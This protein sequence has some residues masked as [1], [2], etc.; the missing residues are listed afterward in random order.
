MFILDNGN[1]GIKAEFYLYSG[2]YVGTLFNMGIF[3]KNIFFTSY[4]VAK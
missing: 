3:I 2:F 1:L 4:K